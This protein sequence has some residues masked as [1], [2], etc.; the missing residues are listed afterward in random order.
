MAGNTEIGG[1]RLGTAWRGVIWGGAAAL[2]ML[3]AI[4]MQFTAEVDWDARDFLIVAVML[5]ALC[6]AIELGARLSASPWYRAAVA[7][8]AGASFLLVWVNLAV[9]MVGSEQNPYNLWFAGVLGVG[10]VGASI[11]RF[12]PRGMALT[13]VAMA[14][15]QV[16]IGGT[17]FVAGRD[18]LGSTFSTLWAGF[19]LLSA[20]LF[21]QAARER[22]R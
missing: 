2:L 16:A 12:R 7:T 17:A 19:W 6:G 1:G 18:P 13:L 10:L 20:A 14:L 8:G 22:S 3:P 5:S 9:G 15:A 4:A 21:W 11:A